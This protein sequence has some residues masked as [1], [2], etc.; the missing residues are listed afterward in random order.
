MYS[1][2]SSQFINP[3]EGYLSLSPSQESVEL[4]Q[5]TLGIDYN[6]NIL[7][8]VLSESSSQ[9]L[10]SSDLLVAPLEVQQ[11]NSSEPS[12]DTFN[13][14]TPNAVLQNK[15]DHFWGKSPIK[16]MKLWLVYSPS[17]QDDALYLLDWFTTHSGIYLF[18]NF[19]GNPSSQNS[20]SQDSLHTLHRPFTCTIHMVT[21]QEFLHGMELDKS[22]F[23]FLYHSSAHHEFTPL[24]ARSAWF[25]T[26]LVKRCR[27]TS[28]R[29]K[30]SDDL[31]LF[32]Q[33]TRQEALWSLIKH[34]ES[35]YIDHQSHELLWQSYQDKTLRLEKIQSFSYIIAAIGLF[36]VCL[37]IWGQST[38]YAWETTFI[39]MSACVI[40]GMGCITALWAWL[41]LRAFKQRVLLYWIDPS[42]N[43]PPDQIKKR[44][45]VIKY[46]FNRSKDHDLFKH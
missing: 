27:V 15:N 42:L 36:G 37:G 39:Y 19:K 12:I 5:V 45:R 13:T 35:T 24:I 9:I 10:H 22:Y 1:S 40:W 20:L 23:L 8:S 16:P 44:S 30:I 6:T 17:L 31:K 11:S 43:T 14:P 3:P 7:P 25:N 41:D 46:K 33:K 28:I 29:G 21:L 26:E 2:P 32:I 34:K 38:D 4:D 18:T